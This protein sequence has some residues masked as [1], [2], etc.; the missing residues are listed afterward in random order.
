L[1]CAGAICASIAILGVL[2]VIALINLPE[3]LGD[4]QAAI[5]PNL[6]PH[7]RA[8]VF[9]GGILINACIA[10]YCFVLLYRLRDRFACK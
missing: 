7:I 5:M 4:F 6:S 3:G 8:S 2:L 10:A 9:V 1:Q